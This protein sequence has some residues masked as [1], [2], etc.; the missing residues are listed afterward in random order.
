MPVAY[1]PPG[2]IVWG[3]FYSNKIARQNANEVDPDLAGNMGHNLVAILK[4]YSKHRIG[5]S[6]NYP[7]FDFNSIFFCQVLTP[8][9]CPPKQ[10]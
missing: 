2:Q 7:S 8:P 6:L 4:L 5:Q 10:V 1:A 9:L 3:K